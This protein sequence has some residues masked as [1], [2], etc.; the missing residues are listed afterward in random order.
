MPSSDTDMETAILQPSEKYR[1]RLLK[2]LPNMER[3][4]M[5]TQISQFC[6]AGVGFLKYARVVQSQE[7]KVEK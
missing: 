7:A 3:K 2:G 6:F 1:L 4:A 5:L